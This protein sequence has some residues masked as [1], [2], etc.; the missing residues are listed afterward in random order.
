MGEALFHITVAWAQL[1]KG[2]L[3]ERTIAGM[4]RARAEGKRIGRPPARPV[5][6]RRAWR[7]VRD[8]VVAGTLTRA[9]G[10]RR[11]RVRYDTFVAAL[12]AGVALRKGGAHQEPPGEL[13]AG[14]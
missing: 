14:A 10:A 13:A 7:E 11:L 9:E 4:E 1:E 5:D 8:L 3:V 6:K 12:N 2:I